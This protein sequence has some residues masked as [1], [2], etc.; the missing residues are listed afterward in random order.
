M[1]ETVNRPVKEE[2][3]KPIGMRDL[4]YLLVL[5]CG[6]VMAWSNLNSTVQDTTRVLTRIETH[7][8]KTDSKVDLLQV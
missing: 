8:D 2:F 7:L 1:V 6:G 4:V 5:L 3:F